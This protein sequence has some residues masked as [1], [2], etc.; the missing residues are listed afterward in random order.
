MPCLPVWWCI[1]SQ[2]FLES[3]DVSICPKT[4]S[5][6]F[7][8]HWPPCLSPTEF[9]SIPKHFALTS[10]SLQAVISAYD[11]FDAIHPLATTSWAFKAKLKYPSLE[12]AFKA[13]PQPIMSELNT[14]FSV[15]PSII[16]L[17]TEHCGSSW[18]PQLIEE[19]CYLMSSVWYLRPR[20]NQVLQ[21]VH[22]PQHVC[23]SMHMLV[24]MGT[25]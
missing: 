23:C 14:A 12:P 2:W 1:P 21:V 8:P 10:E 9:P 11:S 17:K 15:L 20:E 18:A 25:E 7:Q 19:P 6:S 5:S 13:H 3:K 24:Y 4:G 22:W 16:V